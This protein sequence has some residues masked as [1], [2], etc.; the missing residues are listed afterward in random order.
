[1]TKLIRKKGIWFLKFLCVNDEI[2]IFSLNT[3]NLKLAQTNAKIFL[4]ENKECVYGMEK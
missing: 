3:R 2:Y 4:K 1:M